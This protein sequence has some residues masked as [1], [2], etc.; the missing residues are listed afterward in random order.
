MEPAPILPPERP[1]RPRVPDR[2]ETPEHYLERLQRALADEQANLDRVLEDARL[3]ALSY[4]ARR[5]GVGHQTLVDLARLV[6]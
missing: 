1:A 3:F 5:L 6:L 4:A 2:L